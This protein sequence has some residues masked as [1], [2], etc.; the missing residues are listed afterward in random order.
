[1]NIAIITGASS[2]MG[3]ELVFELADRFSG[4]SEI[5][6]IAR[7]TE[8]LKELSGQVPVKLR[9]ISLDLLERDALS[10]LG[11]FLREEKPNVKILANAAG[12]GI[13][14]AVGSMDVSKSADMARLN[15]EAVVG[16]TE[17]V[18]PY[19]KSGS[20][21]IQFASAAAFMPQP[22]F[23]VYAAS[24]S[25]VLS[26]SR[27]LAAE[28]FEKGI[29]VTA[30]C[31]G[32]VDTEFFDTA[33]GKK[34]LAP[35]KK[36]CMAKPKAVVKKAVKDSMMGKEVS[37]YGLPMHAFLVICRVVPHSLLMRFIKW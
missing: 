17:T 22:G 6:V 30:V 15:C 16:V 19:M 29:F 25:F 33:L 32:P 1:M 23:A 27:A 37:V 2:G 4:L 12:F 10:V 21:I 9:I 11:G 5:W 36:L 13:S 14:G 24:K 18:L 34:E 7:R 26:Y 31:P 20:R 35:Y 8:R 3:R 28:L